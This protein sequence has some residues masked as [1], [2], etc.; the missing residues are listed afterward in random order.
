MDVPQTFKDTFVLDVHH[1]LTLTPT[2]TSHKPPQRQTG[3]GA[4]CQRTAVVLFLLLVHLWTW[5]SAAGGPGGGRGGQRGEAETPSR[6]RGHAGHA[7]P[8]LYA[9]DVWVE[10]LFKNRK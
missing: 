10:A 7:A 8:P 5:G 3:S 9:T 6:C 2:T 4:I 1:R